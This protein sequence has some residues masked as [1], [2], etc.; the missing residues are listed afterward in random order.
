MHHL[1]PRA[2]HTRWLPRSS[3]RMREGVQLSNYTRDAATMFLEEQYAA[4]LTKSAGY[5]ARGY[6]RAAARWA[7]VACCLYE[8]LRVVAWPESEREDA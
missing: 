3:V 8:S 4:A 1:L 6:W 7:D 5:M 2:L